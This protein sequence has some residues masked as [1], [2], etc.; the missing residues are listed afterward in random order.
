MNM[1]MKNY[2]KYHGFLGLPRHSKILLQELGY[3]YFG[4]YIGLIMEA[5]WY[6]GNPD[7]GCIKKSQKEL[8]EALNCSQSTISRVLNYLE[9]RRYLIRHRTYI[10]LAYFPL[11]LTEVAFKMHS[12]NYASLQ[13]L[14]ADMSEINAE[15]QQKYTDSQ[16]KRGQTDTQR[17]YS[18]SKGDS[19]FFEDDTSFIQGNEEAEY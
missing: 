8:A 5:I 16:R 10:R 18:S 4:L 7:L 3:E 15:L 11:F 19:G 9:R 1:K 12:R 2:K 14:Y 13:E 6:R 17:L